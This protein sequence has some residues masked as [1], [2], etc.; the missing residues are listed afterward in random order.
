MKVESI[1]ITI[2]TVIV[3]ITIY[4]YT[5]LVT[6]PS[7]NNIIKTIFIPQGASFSIIAKGLE[8][9]GIVTDAEK[10]LVLARFKGAIT[11]IKAGEYEF[12]T[13]ML[14]NE[15]LN[16][17][18]YGKTKN[19]TITIPEGYNTI[20]IAKVLSNMNIVDEDKFLNRAMDET[21]A[22]SL[23]IDGNTV[24][25]YLFPDTYRFTKGI[26]AEEIIKKMTERFNKVYIEI[27]S[28]RQ[29]AL[30]M[31]M[32]Q[33]VTLAS[34]IEKETGANNERTIIAAVFHNRIKK[35]MR[36]ESDPTV[37]YGIKGFNG[38][39]TRKDLLNKTPYNTYQ[40]YGLPPGP[41]ANPG[42]ASLEAAISPSEE[43][44]LYFVSNNNGGHYFSNNLKEHNKAVQL[45]QK[46]RRKISTTQ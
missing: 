32:R 38:N 8:K 6:P 4:V 19:Y 20:E 42:R 41:I 33:I 16:R 1:F 14:P 36:L 17:M 29:S 43:Q 24:E 35:G 15:V 11:K 44:Y 37:I 46:E 45:Y 21:F 34:I 13:S 39:L 10:F 3:L 40:I 30:K 25:G 12:T 22:A 23:N 7:N 5:F 31:S 2:L 27:V 9:E 26:T 28:N 18:L